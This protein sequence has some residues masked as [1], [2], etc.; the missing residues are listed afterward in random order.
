MFSFCVISTA[1][2]SQKTQNENIVRYSPTHANGGVCFKINAGFNEIGKG[3]LC[4]YCVIDA[5][6]QL[7]DRPVAET[8]A[9]MNH[10][11]RTV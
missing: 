9:T 7:D 5:V 6:K 2:L 11:I 4:K 8:Q 10:V 3:D 1:Q